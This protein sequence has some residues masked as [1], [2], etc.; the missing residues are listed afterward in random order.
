M[1]KKHLI[2]FVSLLVL[3]IFMYFWL[4]YSFSSDAQI[5]YQRLI[6]FNDQF[7]LE[8]MKEDGRFTQQTREQVSKQIIYKKDLNRLQSRLASEHSELIFSS[9]GNHSELVEHFNGLICVMQEKLMDAPKHLNPEGSSS[10]NL[11][12]PNQYIRCLKAHEAL[13]SYKTGQLEAEAVEIEHYLVP[14]LLYPPT[15]DAYHPLFRGR[16]QRLQLSLFKE[17]TLKAQGFQA[18]F[19]DREGEW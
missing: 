7:K 15:L 12:Q 8:Q 16:A 10:Q 3:F 2:S 18:A 13:Y 11:L 4:F 9:K 17:P 1:F 14:G 19:H 6:S 5:A